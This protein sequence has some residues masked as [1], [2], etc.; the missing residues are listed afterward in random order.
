[1]PVSCMDEGFDGAPVPVQPPAPF[2]G[3]VSCYDPIEDDDIPMG[4]GQVIDNSRYNMEF[5][6]ETRRG[7][8]NGINLYRRNLALIEARID[9]IETGAPL[10]PIPNTPPDLHEFVGVSREDMI[11]ELLAIRQTERDAM[12]DLRSR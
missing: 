9:H 7:I 10:L 4:Y 12:D 11:M 2:A 1:M 5:A 3:T 6:N 8:L